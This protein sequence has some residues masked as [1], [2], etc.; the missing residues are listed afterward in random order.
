MTSDARLVIDFSLGT[1]TG[2]GLS[3]ARAAITRA[4][5]DQWRCS[6]WGLP[7]WSHNRPTHSG[8]LDTI[9]FAG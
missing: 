4:G 2:F 3:R 7:K 9:F 1:P 8:W 6:V 5:N